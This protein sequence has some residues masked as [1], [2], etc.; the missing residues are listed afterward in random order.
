MFKLA[1]TV[2]NRLVGLATDDDASASLLFSGQLVKNCS[3]YERSRR[4]LGNS[5]S[6]KYQ[7]SFETMLDVP[8]G[9][10]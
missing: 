3:L 4:F 10:N 5:N 1:L 9:I 6:K 2:R 7:V 8:F